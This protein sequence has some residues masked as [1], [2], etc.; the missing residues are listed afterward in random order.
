[1]PPSDALLTGDYLKILYVPP[2][3]VVFHGLTQL[4]RLIHP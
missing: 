2:H 1:M 4:D 3:G